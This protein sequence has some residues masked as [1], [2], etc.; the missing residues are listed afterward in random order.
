MLVIADRQKLHAHLARLG[1]ARE[2]LREESRSMLPSGD[3][4]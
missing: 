2:R 3:V 4:S 1:N